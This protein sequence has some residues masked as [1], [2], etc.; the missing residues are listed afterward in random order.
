[1]VSYISV[2]IFAVF[3]ALILLTA[4]LVLLRRSDRKRWE[5]VRSELEAASGALLLQKEELDQKLNH[6][7]RAEAD[8][9]AR[10]AECREKCRQKEENWEEQTRQSAARYRELSRSAGR[11]HLYAQL[12]KEQCTEESGW[13]QCDVILREC[14]SIQNQIDTSSY[15]EKAK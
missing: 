10:E 4:L 15:N 7:L 8:A 12:V 13:A 2:V 11:I 5:Q 1:M 9:Q 6:L 3:A 14:E